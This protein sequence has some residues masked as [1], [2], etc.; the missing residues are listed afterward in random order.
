MEKICNYSKDVLGVVHHL[1]LVIFFRTGIT[2]LRKKQLT[3]RLPI[4]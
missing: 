4:F 3:E 1:P 2:L